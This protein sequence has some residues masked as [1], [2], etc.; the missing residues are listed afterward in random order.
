VDDS[1]RRPRGGDKLRLNFSLH[2]RCRSRSRSRPPQELGLIF[3]DLGRDP[4]PSIG[5]QAA[6]GG[7][8]SALAGVG[9]S[10]EDNEK[11]GHGECEA[12]QVY[13]PFGRLSFAENGNQMILPTS[14]YYECNRHMRLPGS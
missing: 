2:E 14:E 11:A 13:L 1:E 8:K 6:E 7:D 4:K 3:S 12:C 5:K 10:A 9:G